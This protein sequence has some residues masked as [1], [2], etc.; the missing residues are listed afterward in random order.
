ME[1]QLD[2]HSQTTLFEQI[3]T[4]MLDRMYQGEWPPGTKLPSQRKL[5]EQLGVNRSTIIDVLDELKAEG[6]LESKTGSGTYVAHNS[7]QTLFP[8][9]YHWKERIRAGIHQPN[10]QTIQLINEYETKEIIR[11]GTGELSPSLLPTKQLEEVLQSISLDPRT[12]GY[13]EPKGHKAL[14]HA[15][16]VHLQKRGI[17]TSPDCILIVSGALQALQLISLGLLPQ[18]S[19]IYY[20]APSY[21][22]SLHLFQSAGMRLSRLHS[23]SENITYSKSQKH[24]LFYTI[25]TLNNPSG[26]ILTEAERHDLYQ[27]WTNLQIP[28]VE[29]DVYNELAFSAI[30]PAIKSVDTAGNVLYLGSLS[31]TVSPGLRIGWVVAPE[32][33]VDRLADIKMQFDYG[34]SGF[35]QLLA[36]TWLASPHHET[37]MQQLRE[38]LQQRATFTEALLV[39]HFHNIAVWQKP[40]GGFYIWLRFHQPLVTKALFLKLLQKGVLLHPGYLYDR[41]NHHHLRL[42]FAYASLPE[43]EKGIDLLAQAVKAMTT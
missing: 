21:I 11:L 3:Y 26:T 28:I 25:P 22:E 1:I 15:V 4:R 6:W 43:L 42:S 9:Q 8:R 29:D 39:K 23:G 5:A 35:S 2:R 32:P 33:V 24:G 19:T 30:P 12:I 14:R 17:Q 40:K 31:K 27:H 38:N 37:H 20:E 34:A 36:A 7:W 18:H 13:S 10:L 41:D 16:A